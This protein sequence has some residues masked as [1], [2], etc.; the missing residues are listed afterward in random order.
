MDKYLRGKDFCPPRMAQLTFCIDL[1]MRLSIMLFPTKR[2]KFVVDKLMFISKSAFIS[3]NTKFWK[4]VVCK[5][6][7]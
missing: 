7:R 2:A 6:Q 4:G 5:S 1:S 3:E